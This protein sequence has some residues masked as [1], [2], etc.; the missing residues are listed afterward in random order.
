M[1]VM[2]RLHGLLASAG[3]KPNIA[4]V[5]ALIAAPGPSADPPAARDTADT[6][7]AATDKDLLGD[8]PYRAPACSVLRAVAKH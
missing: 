8:E 2:G 4:R 7:L 5:R 3:C 6:D 1:L